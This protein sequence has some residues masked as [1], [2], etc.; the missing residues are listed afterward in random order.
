MKKGSKT[1][2]ITL[3]G[4]PEPESHTSTTTYRSEIK[5]SSGASRAPTRMVSL[6]P[7][8]IASRALIARFKTANSSWLASARVHSSSPSKTVV[9]L[10]DEP[11]DM[12]MMSCIPWS[13]L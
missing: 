9:Y 10:I 2:A 7:L 6:P 8:G 5:V 11:R 12:E 4:I 1:R 13:T 3:A